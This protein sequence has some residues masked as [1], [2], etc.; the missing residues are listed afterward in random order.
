MAT[1]RSM[2]PVS[3]QI[4]GNSFIPRLSAVQMQ[5][6]LARLSLMVNSLAYHIDTQ[7]ISKV[8]WVANWSQVE[9]DDLGRVLT[10]LP[11]RFS[12]DYQRKIMPRF[13]G[14]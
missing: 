9:G 5:L 1:G 11:K 8:S 2:A 13:G 14:D 7:E 4:H 12:E 10:P 3:I 6:L